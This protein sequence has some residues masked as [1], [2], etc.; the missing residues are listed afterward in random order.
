MSTFGHHNRQLNFF[1]PPKKHFVNY[2]KFFSYPIDSG[3]WSNDKSFF[4][5]YPTHFGRCTNYFKKCPNNLVVNL[6]NQI[7]LVIKQGDPKIFIA[8]K[9]N[10]NVLGI[11]WKHLGTNQ[12]FLGSDK[13]IFNCQINDH[14]KLNH[15]FLGGNS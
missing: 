11:T 9:G 15:Y 2:S 5:H 4:C 12:N 8:G 3:H 6:G 10:Q 13:N 1:G 7:F 14:Y